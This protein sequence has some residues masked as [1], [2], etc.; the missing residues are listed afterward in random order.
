MEGWNSKYGS[1]NIGFGIVLA[2]II[3]LIISS[4]ILFCINI[5]RLSKQR[6]SIANLKKD[7]AA[8]ELQI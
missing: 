5:S 3:V 8:V 2:I 1:A 6:L 4:G 7:L